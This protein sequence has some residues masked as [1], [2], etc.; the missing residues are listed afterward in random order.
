MSSVRPIAFYLP[1]YHPIPENDEWWGTGFT[2]WRNVVR[3]TPRFPGHYQPHLPAD[4]GFYDLRLPEVRQAQADLAKEYGIYGFCYYHYWM[5]GKRL[6]ERPFEE[7]LNSGKPDFP[8]ALCWANENWTRRWD[9]FDK[10]ILARQAYS[11]E[12][13][14]RHIKWL[15][16]AFL[17]PRYIRI[18]GKPLFL[19]YRAAELPNAKQTIEIFRTEAH[20]H[21]IGEI[22][23]CNTESNPQQYVHSHGS[24]FD[25]AVEF[26]PRWDNLGKPIG[27]RSRLRYWARRLG[28][29][30]P[31]LKD[32]VF[33]YQTVIE[34]MMMLDEPDYLRFSCV[35]PSWDNSARRAREAYVLTGS[36]P[37]LYEKW[38]RF[39]VERTLSRPELNGVLFINAWNEW[40]EGNHLEPCQ[41]WGRAYLE[42]TRS[43]IQPS[44]QVFRENRRHDET[45]FR[46]DLR[47]IV[48]DPPVS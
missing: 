23:L 15:A 30:S 6:L 48:E 12:D 32:T 47:G 17:D 16:K 4:L 7:V 44:T 9:G 18:D 29:E 40:A 20:K 21:G 35:T 5:E 38:L 2:E 8:F 22:F 33:D 27:Q 39:A 1:Q 41:K 43:A 42:A 28:M 19:I 46:Q 10:E 13:D 37:S 31:F 14:V 36:T 34:R 26:Q 3:A 24:G 45:D 11:F 25:A